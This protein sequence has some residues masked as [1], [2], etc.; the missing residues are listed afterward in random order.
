MLQRNR[1]VRLVK[2]RCFFDHPRVYTASKRLTPDESESRTCAAR[3]ER[4][5]ESR[6]GAR[7]HEPDFWTAGRTLTGI[8]PQLRSDQAAC[9]NLYH[10][11]SSCPGS[12]IWTW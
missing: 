3:A 11:T 10:R 9:S 8:L 6:R 12:F 1:S 2:S 7:F 5:G 4:L